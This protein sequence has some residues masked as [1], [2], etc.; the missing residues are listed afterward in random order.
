MAIFPGRIHYIFDCILAFAL[1]FVCFQ[2]GRSYV[3]VKTSCPT[4]QNVNEIP[5]WQ[6]ILGA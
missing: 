6:D 3:F 4:A 1:I 2:T 5:G